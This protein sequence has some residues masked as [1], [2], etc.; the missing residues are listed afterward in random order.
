MRLFFYTFVRFVRNMLI[1]DS[2]WHYKTSNIVD[3]LQID[4][5]L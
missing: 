1:D 2:R 4:I 3:S 5:E